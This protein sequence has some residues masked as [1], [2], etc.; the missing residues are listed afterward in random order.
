MNNNNLN[1]ISTFPQD[2][3]IYITKYI[4]CQKCVICSKK[5]IDYQ[6]KS[7]S[8]YLCSLLCKTIYIIDI[9]PIM[10]AHYSDTV[11]FSFFKYGTIVH[12]FTLYILSGIFHTTLSFIIFILTFTVMCLMSIL[13]TI[14]RLI[15]A[16]VVVPLYC[17]TCLKNLK[18]K[19]D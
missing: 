5:I 19:Y 11:I 2:I 15:T 13:V 10:F 18:I 3:K 1:V 16:L 8:H 9:S 14:Y 4:S 6:E 12:Y 17:I 7:K